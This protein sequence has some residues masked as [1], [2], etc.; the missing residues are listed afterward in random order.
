MK[1]I[2]AHY[3]GQAK[4]STTNKNIVTQISDLPDKKEV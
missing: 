2:K 4:N 1:E 3:N